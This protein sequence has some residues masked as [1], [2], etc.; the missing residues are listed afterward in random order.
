[1]PQKILVTGG[2]GFIG[3]HLVTRLLSMGHEVV[4]LDNFQTGNASNHAEH[5]GHPKFTLVRHDVYEPISIEADRIYNMACPASP[6]HYQA[7]HV[8]TLQTCVVGS[9]NMLDLAVENGA[10]ILQ[11]ST[12]EVYGDPLVHPQV[13]SYLGNVNS[14]GERSCY[15]EGKRCAE[16][17]FYAYRK[18]R[19]ADIRIAR[20]FNTYGPGMQA[21][22]GRVVSNFVVQALRNQPITIYGDGTQTRSFCYVD[23]L[24]DG[25]VRLM[26]GATQEPVNLGNPIEFTMRELADLVVELTGSSSSIVHLPLPADDPRLRRPDISRARTELGWQPGVP[27]RDGLLPTIAYFDKALGQP[28]PRLSSVPGTAGRRDAEQS[29]QPAN[30][31]ADGLDAR[32]ASGGEHR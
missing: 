10:R 3:S 4:S 31:R 28:R 18:E 6:V 11:A 16:A 30:D 15:D 29:Y 24:V 5:L 27:L 14:F 17:L 13:E 8:K 19:N 21:D 25:L 7:D 22:D 2:A 23:D 26:E 9:M 12:S 32:L 20:I 1:M